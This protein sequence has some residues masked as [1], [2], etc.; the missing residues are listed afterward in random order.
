MGS[1]KL[2]YHIVDSS[3]GPDSSRDTLTGERIFAL[4]QKVV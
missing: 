2:L 3:G 4:S 1:T